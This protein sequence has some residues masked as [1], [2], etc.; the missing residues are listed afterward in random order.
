MGIRLSLCQALQAVY[1]Q[2]AGLPASASGAMLLMHCRRLAGQCAAV[3][4]A[5]LQA[6]G[7]WDR[8]WTRFRSP[9]AL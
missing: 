3:L 1:G 2:P 7:G 4:M 8:R 5:M 6:E 9:P